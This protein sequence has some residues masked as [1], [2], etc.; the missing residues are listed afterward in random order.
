MNLLRPAYFFVALGLA[1]A[2]IG[3]G[4][5]VMLIYTYQLPHYPGAVRVG[6]GQIGLEAGPEGGFSEHQTFY[7]RDDMS[8]VLGWYLKRFN[9]RSPPA[10]TGN[11]LTF[12]KGTTQLF[13][14][15]EMSLR[16]CQHIDRGTWIM[17]GRRLSLGAPGR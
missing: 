3:L 13:L 6:A 12:T 10:P 9:F 17:V 14:R 8:D 1:I 7:A 2:L 11:C 16:L 4:P 15:Q 5:L